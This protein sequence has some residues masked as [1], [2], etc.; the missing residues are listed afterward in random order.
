MTEPSRKAEQ[1]I[2]KVNNYL[3]EGEQQ[4]ILSVAHHRFWLTVRAATSELK[5]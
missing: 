1:N 5:Y 2:L 4:R 3:K